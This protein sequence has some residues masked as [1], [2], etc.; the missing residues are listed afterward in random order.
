MLSED[1][2]RR[3]MTVDPAQIGHY[4]QG[5]FMRP[6]IKP[7]FKSA[8]IVGPAFTVK[9]PGKDSTV[10]YYAMKRAPEGR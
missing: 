8:K 3:F 5:G 7:I 1:M 4:I 6:S 2:K 10:L 9:M